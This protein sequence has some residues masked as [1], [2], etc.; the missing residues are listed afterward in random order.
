M[1]CCLLRNFKIPFF[2]S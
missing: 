2:G 1:S